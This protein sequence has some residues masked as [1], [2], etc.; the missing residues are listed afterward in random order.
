ME[1][2]L[3]IVFFALGLLAQ[4]FV[5]FLRKQRD[6]AEADPNA[7]LEFGWKFIRP[8]VLSAIIVILVSPM[9]VPDFRDLLELYWQSAFLL[10][11]GSA[12][13]GHEFA[14]GVKTVQTIR[15]NA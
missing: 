3:S 1:L 10:G 2:V 7:E 12:A 9:V 11:F 14:Q 6:L 13:L 8:K 15:K 4:V 5:P